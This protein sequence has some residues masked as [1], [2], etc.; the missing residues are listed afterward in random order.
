[1]LLWVAQCRTQQAYPSVQRSVLSSIGVKQ[2]ILE[3]V[4]ASVQCVLSVSRSAALMMAVGSPIHVPHIQPGQEGFNEAV[5]A[6]HE[7]LVRALVAL[8][9][10]Y[11]VRAGRSC[12]HAH[13]EWCEFSALGL[14]MQHWHEWLCFVLGDTAGPAAAGCERCRRE[15]RPP[16]DRGAREAR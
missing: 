3:A 10:K 2:V 12:C 14:L 8:Y 4:C 7:Q 6:A 11:K 15:A 13:I 16:F 1:M 5:D 9:D